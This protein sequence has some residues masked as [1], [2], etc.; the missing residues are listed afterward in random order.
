MFGD[1]GAQAVES[2]LGRNQDEDEPPERDFEFKAD[3]VYV[4]PNG[5]FYPCP[6]MG[7]RVLADRIFRHVD[8]GLAGRPDYED[9]E[10]EADRLNWL[11]IQPSALRPGH[12]EIMSPKGRPTPRQERSLV[13]WCLAHDYPYPEDLR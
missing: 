3:G 9:V 1:L 10:R 13:D 12:F 6:Y 4:L 2:M 7:H 11:R 5:D 8:L